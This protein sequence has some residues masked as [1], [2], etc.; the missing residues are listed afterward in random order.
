[1]SERFDIE[2]KD[3]AKTLDAF[4]RI[5]TKFLGGVDDKA[6]QE[7]VNKLP[8]EV[9]DIAAAGHRAVNGASFDSATFAQPFTPEN[10]EKTLQGLQKKFGTALALRVICP[11]LI[12]AGTKDMGPWYEGVKGLNL[13]VQAVANDMDPKRK[14]QG[15]QAQPLDQR[16]LASRQKWSNAYQTFVEKMVARGK[17]A[18]AAASSVRPSLFAQRD[19]AQR[20]F[21]M[22][23]FMRAPGRP[24]RGRGGERERE[25]S[26][27][28]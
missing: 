10:K 15:E 20:A 24:F 3:P 27:G 9:C 2:A 4:D 16:V 26:P 1:M 25:A 21:E 19:R 17:P 28:L 6:I 13:L 22:A 18:L 14:G 12:D 23:P 5:M 7:A 11:M 8:Q